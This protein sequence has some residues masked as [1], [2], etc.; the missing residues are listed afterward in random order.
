MPPMRIWGPP[1]TPQAPSLFILPFEKNE[2]SMT[3]TASVTTCAFCQIQFDWAEAYGKTE[4]NRTKPKK[5]ALCLRCADTWFRRDCARCGES[6]GPMNLT[7]NSAAYCRPCAREVRA[8]HKGGFKVSD[9]RAE[10]DCRWCL[11][12]FIPA[13]SDSKCCSRNCH[14]SFNDFQR[15][16][17]LEFR[18]SILMLCACGQYARRSVG[19]CVECAPPGEYR[20]NRGKAL[21]RRYLVE[22]AGDV[23]IN[24][25]ALGRRNGWDCHL[26][27]EP[28][29]QKAGT[30]YEPFGATVDHLIPIVDGGTHTWDNVALAHRRCNIARGAK[31][32]DRVCNGES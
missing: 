9:F 24:W 30:A 20:M 3:T 19:K 16:T 17:G 5:N 8:L 21:R 32:L 29:L 6:F 27:G 11:T 13:R 25:R 7:G 23:G 31:P 22:K 14:L 1:K 12:R 10:A 26:C 15:R 28:V 2:I 4:S 18:A